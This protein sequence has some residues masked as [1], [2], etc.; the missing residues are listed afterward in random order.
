MKKR[1]LLATGNP[2]KLGEMKNGLKVLANLGW[3]LV[4]LTDL[5]INSE[6]EETGKSFRENALLK[7][8]YYAN[9]SS[10]PSIA[11]DGGFIIPVLNF[12]P[13]IYSRRWLG[14][15][16]SDDALIAH[17]LAKMQPYKGKNREAYL[18]LVLCFYDPQFGTEIFEN[19]KI[20]G[21][22]ADKPTTKR[23]KGFPYRALLKV[24]PY[25][26]Y[27]DELLETE[28]RVV[29]HRLRALAKIVPKLQKLYD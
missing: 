1:L 29:N 24:E 15:D 14:Y 2:G 13:G 25:D 28:H 26:K 21:T 11:D 20:R 23:I 17:T 9:L 27:Y 6:P 10:L 4:G 5:G 19:E 18:E 7:A 22:I 8:R 16:S 12:E 3:E